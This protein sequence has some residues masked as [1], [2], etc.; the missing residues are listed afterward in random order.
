MLFFFCI[1]ETSFRMSISPRDRSACA[2]PPLLTFKSDLTYHRCFNLDF[3]YRNEIFAN[4]LI[5][6]PVF[7]SLVPITIYYK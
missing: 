6:S 5:F 2:A 1:P 4:H 3:C 7:F